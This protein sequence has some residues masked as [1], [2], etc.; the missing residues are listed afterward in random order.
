[1]SKNNYI[2][3]V[4][5]VLIQ[6]L[7]KINCQNVLFK[8]TKRSSHT[9]TLID[10]NLYI[11]GGRDELFTRRIGKEFFYLDVTVP[12][13]TQNILW[14]DLTSINTVPAHMAAAS[15]KGGV[16][17]N[18]LFLYV[19]IPYDNTE[20]MALIYAFDTRS[21]SWGI[22]K[23]SDVTIG[24]KDNLKGIVDDNG[25]MYLFGGHTSVD[26]YRNDMIIFDT[27][28]LDWKIGSSINA[29]SP[30]AVFG[31]TL[32]SDHLIIYIGGIDNLALSLNEVYIYDTIN[33]N[34]STKGQYLP[35]EIPFLLFLVGLD[36][37]RVII[38][39]GA[40]E[41]ENLQSQNALYVLN[42]INYE[43]Y[44]PKISGKIPSPRRWHE[45]NVIGK[46]M[47]V[48]FGRGY[49]DNDI[50]L[51]DISNN[52]EYIW[53]DSFDPTFPIISPSP[54]TPSTD[55]S[56][57]QPNASPTQT[58]QLQVPIVIGI[59]IGSLSVGFFLALG[60]FFLYR[61]NKNRRESEKAIPTTEIEEGNEV[62]IIP[63][64]KINN[65]EQGM[66]P[67]TPAYNSAYY[68]EQNILSIP[69]NTYGQQMLPISQ[70]NYNIYNQN[71]H[72]QVLQNSRKVYNHGSETYPGAK[73]QG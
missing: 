46:Y 70:N 59:A 28:N 19:G 53:T 36:G 55:P 69:G 15:V 20:A 13:N 47:V 71:N 56:K 3:I 54:K 9:S 10:G 34:W 25:K 62:V 40:K 67:N 24:R 1:M 12:F 38:F 42:L 41:Y 29:P 61:W 66:I 52:E 22:P 49:E 60:V 32:I 57:V 45:A 33:D 43:W 27:L 39:G 11:L 7:I 30:R 23:M 5:W 14:H 65:Y 68:H 8:P 48:S 64:Q 26:D 44:I 73:I 2:H 35:T 4:S 18:T 31:S 37:Q 6:L 50:L 21:Y 51:L 58:T 16:H 72:E 17:N 63:T